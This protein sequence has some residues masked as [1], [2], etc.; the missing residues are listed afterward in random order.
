LVFT[1]IDTIGDARAISSG[2]FLDHDSALKAL[3][4]EL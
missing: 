1:H 3:E 4:V 2:Y